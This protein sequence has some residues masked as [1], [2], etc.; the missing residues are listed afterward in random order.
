MRATVKEIHSGIYQVFSWNLIQYQKITSIFVCLDDGA[1]DN[2]VV[3]TLCYKP[4]GYVFD[5]R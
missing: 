2:V 5:T 4:E 3:M 1:R